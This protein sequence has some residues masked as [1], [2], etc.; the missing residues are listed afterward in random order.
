M[1]QEGAIG[2]KGRGSRIK[3]EEGGRRTR[4]DPGPLTLDPRPSTLDLPS[5]LARILIVHPPSIRRAARNRTQLAPVRRTAAHGEPAYR[6]FLPNLAGFTGVPL[7]RTRP[8]TPLTPVRPL[9]GRPRAGVQ[10][11]YSGLRVQ[12]T[13]SSPSST[14]LGVPRRGTST[15]LLPSSPIRAAGRHTGTSVCGAVPIIADSREK[16]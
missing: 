2:V 10:P 12:G 3:G 1:R 14:T 16:G 15:K 4:R 11:R 9:H 13:A 8:S 7:R 5:L 6:C